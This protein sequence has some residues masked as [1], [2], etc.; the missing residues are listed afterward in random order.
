MVLMIFLAIISLPLPSVENKNV[1]SVMEAEI[2][3]NEAQLHK[4]MDQEVFQ[5]AV[6]GFNKIQGL[7]NDSIITIIDFSKPSTVERLFIIDLKN[8]KTIKS[9]LVAHGKNSGENY[10]VS[11]SNASGS[12]KSCL[13][14][15][16]TAETYYGKHGYSLRLDGLEKGINDNSRDRSVVIHGASYVSSSFSEINGRLGRS[17]GCPAIPLDTSAEIINLIKNKS[18]LFIYANDKEYLKTSG[19][20]N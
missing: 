19:F 5:L 12:L 8:K 2:I 14:F 18:C 9:S 1:I 10:A 17:W 13:G 11:F 3:Y 20:I 6:S 7:E 4:Y 16:L 15:F